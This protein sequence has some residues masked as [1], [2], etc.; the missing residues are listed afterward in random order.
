MSDQWQP[1][2]TAPKDGTDI[3]IADCRVGGGFMNVVS[4]EVND[5]APWV[6][7]TADG[8]SYHED[9]FTHWMS[10]PNPPQA[11]EQEAQA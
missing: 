2:E 9:A 10:L 1:I 8:I 3:L 11:E 4:Y 7:H 5:R 6:W